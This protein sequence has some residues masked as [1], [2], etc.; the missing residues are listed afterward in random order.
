MTTEPLNEPHESALNIGRI[1]SEPI[2]FESD[3]MVACVN[4]RRAN[5]PNRIKCLYCGNELERD[6][7]TADLIKPVLRKLEGWEKGFN[8][9]YR[10]AL[11]R[12]EDMLGRI[13]DLLGRDLEDVR[14]IFDSSAP[15]PIARIGT[16]REAELLSDTLEQLGISCSIV[17]D[18]QLDPGWLPTRIR[19]LRFDV[20]KIVLT[21]F[22]T[23]E[24]IAVEPNDL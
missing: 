5:P 23:D 13:A 16:N 12:D 3:E 17:S 11:K 1:Q 10:P 22:N 6:A 2:A 24:V 9:I 4:C 8:L 19:G 14:T 18:Q 15:V 21:D 20:D 7:K